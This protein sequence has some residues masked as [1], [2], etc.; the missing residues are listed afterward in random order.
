MG[1][2]F[3][4]IVTLLPSRCGFFFV[5]GRGVSYLVGSSILLSVV[6]QQLVAVFVVLQEEMSTHP[7]TPP[8]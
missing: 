3:T 2:D 8:S 6:D 7:A 1:L 5:F 4:M